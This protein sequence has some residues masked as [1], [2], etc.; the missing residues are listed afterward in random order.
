ME[1]DKQV[2]TAAIVAPGA[3][4]NLRE[5]PNGGGGDGGGETLQSSSWLTGTTDPAILESV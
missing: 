4:T 3:T 1:V 5:G 2:D